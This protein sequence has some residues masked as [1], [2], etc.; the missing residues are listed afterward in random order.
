MESSS[1]Q[2]PDE[3]QLSIPPGYSIREMPD[4]RNY[5]VPNF[6]IDATNLAVQSESM[7][8]SLKVGEAPGGVSAFNSSLHGKSLASAGV[9]VP[10]LLRHRSLSQSSACFSCI[11]RHCPQLTYLLHPAAFNGKP[12]TGPNLKRYRGG[13]CSAGMYV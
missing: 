3:S 5:I 6:M 13:T 12:L 2:A 11:Q 1:T 4:G 8:R 7:K 10:V 9:Y